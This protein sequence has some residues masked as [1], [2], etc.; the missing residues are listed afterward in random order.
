MAQYD[1]YTTLALDTLEKSRK[2][3]GKE[4]F[5]QS[6]AMVYAILALAGAIHEKDNFN[7]TLGGGIITQVSGHMNTSAM[8]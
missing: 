7:I 4:A 3:V 8:R 2:T 5:L 6:K 1:T